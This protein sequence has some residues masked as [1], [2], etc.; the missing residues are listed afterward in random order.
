MLLDTLSPTERLYELT[1]ATG[2][3]P[4]K[5][6]QRLTERDKRVALAENDVNYRTMKSFDFP[7]DAHYRSQWHLHRLSSDARFD[8]RS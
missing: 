6:V 5:L 8:A 1:D 2:M 3:N 7:S 4:V